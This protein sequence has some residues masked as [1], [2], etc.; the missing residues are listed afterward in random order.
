MYTLDT[1]LSYFIKNG[2]KKN[3]ACQESVSF[4]E[5]LVSQ[6]KN[7][8]LRDISKV[9]LKEGWV[10]QTLQDYDG[11]FDSDV[12]KEFFKHIKDPMIAF[13][14]HIKLKNLDDE[15]ELIIRQ[16]FEGKLPTAE[17]ELRTEKVKRKK[18]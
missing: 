15:D 3:N 6:K 18:K 9:D 14:L 10:F 13:Q 5:N 8:T 17:E 1:K 2:L 16:K 11:V 7:I 4:C 12:R